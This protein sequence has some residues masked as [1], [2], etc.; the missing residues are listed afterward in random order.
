MRLGANAAP[1][2][3]ERLA[4]IR[5]L[6]EAVEAARFPVLKA[7][8]KV[9]KCVARP[10]YG[11]HEAWNG[12]GKFHDEDDFKAYCAMVREKLAKLNSTGLKATL[13]VTDSYDPHKAAR[14]AFREQQS[15]CLCGCLA[16]DH[17]E[18]KD[19]NL[20]ECSHCQ[21]CDHFKSPVIERI[22]A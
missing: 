15:H 20:L 16:T 12:N 8:A 13:E 11:I 19:G 1:E 17:R 21:D 3:F 18:D 4:I 5:A 10:G 7:S 2:Q 6:S 14:D 9:K 22:A